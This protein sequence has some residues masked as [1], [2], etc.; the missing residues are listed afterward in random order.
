MK[1]GKVNIIE[2]NGGKVLIDESVVLNSVQE[3]YHVGMP[4]ETSILSDRPGA[5]VK[6]GPNCRIHGTYIHATKSILIGESVLIAAGTTIVDSNGHTSDPELARYRR[7]FQDTSQEISIGDYVWIG[8]NVLIF[9]GVSIGECAVVSA[10]SVVKSDV[11]AY[12][13]VEGNPARVV[14]TIAKEDVLPAGI[15]MSQLREK[16]GFFEY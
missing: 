5:L 14:K 11:P 15:P 8:M 2:K 16:P 7:Y 13:V 1:H 10:G 12:S 6:I 4:F 9:K 3:G